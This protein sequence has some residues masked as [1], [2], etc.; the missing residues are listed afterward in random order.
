[1]KGIIITLSILSVC[2]FEPK[3]PASMEFQRIGYGLHQ[4]M[5]S[6]N[7]F[8]EEPFSGYI[9]P[10]RL[11]STIKL[12][13]IKTTQRSRVYNSYGVKSFSKVS[14]PGRRIILSESG[15]RNLALDPTLQAEYILSDYLQLSHNIADHKKIARIAIHRLLKCQPDFLLVTK[16][17]SDKSLANAKNVKEHQVAY[18]SAR[19]RDEYLK[20]QK[21]EEGID[22]YYYELGFYRKISFIRQVEVDRYV[23]SP[24]HAFRYQR[25]LVKIIKGLYHGES[26]EVSPY[27]FNQLFNL[28]F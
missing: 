2:A 14:K 28:F 26:R 23:V 12:S 6:C 21:G 7:I 1:M 3:E 24:A 20:F 17:L 16:N 5:S 15:W 8:M 22:V 18:L 9:S 19:G 27:K 11:L 13:E 25:W 4:Q 10:S